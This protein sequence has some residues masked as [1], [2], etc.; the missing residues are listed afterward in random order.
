MNRND[1]PT[2]H[3]NRPTSRRLHRRLANSAVSVCAS[4]LTVFE[5][6]TAAVVSLPKDVVR[7]AGMFELL[8]AELRIAE[9]EKALAEAREVACVDPLTGALNRRGFDKAY[10]RE[11]ARARR[12]G[13]PFALAHIDLDDFKRLNDTFGHQV[14]DRALVHLVESLQNSMR[15]SD[16]LCRFGGEEFVLMLPETD[17]NKASSAISRFLRE[18]SAHSIP[19]TDYAMTFSAGVVVQS[20]DESL[21]DAIQRADAATYAAKHA[22]KNCVVTCSGPSHLER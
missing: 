13:I 3:S 16:V 21:E 17:L 2:A 19:G 8:A 6:S 10:S 18:F 9:L 1:S 5:K 4:N 14:G 7:E 11:L 20:L 12:R 22:G 15:P